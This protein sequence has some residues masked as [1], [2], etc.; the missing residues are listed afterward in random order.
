MSTDPEPRNTKPDKEDKEP[1]KLQV[2]KLR[3]PGSLEKALL[4]PVGSARR[5]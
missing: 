3:D 1:R 5:F 2:R 4:C